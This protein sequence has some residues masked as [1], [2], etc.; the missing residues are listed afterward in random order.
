LSLQILFG[1]LVAAS[2][3][4]FTP[5]SLNYSPARDRSNEV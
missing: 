5:L 3:V 2:Q 1:I 4:I